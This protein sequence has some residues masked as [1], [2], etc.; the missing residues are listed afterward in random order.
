MECDA[1]MGR[2]GSGI[3]DGDGSKCGLP[4]HTGLHV[5]AVAVQVFDQKANGEMGGER[6]S[7][8]YVHRWT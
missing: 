1:S 3:L 6:S 2:E 8:V 7:A 5:C 4:C